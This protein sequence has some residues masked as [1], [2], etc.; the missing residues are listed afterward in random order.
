MEPQEGDS[1]EEAGGTF[2][3]VTWVYTYGKNRQAIH[4]KLVHFSVDMLYLHFTK[5]HFKKQCTPA[6]ALTK[7]DAQ[8]Y[9]PVLF[10]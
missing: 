9:F 2:I 10:L 1:G 8:T 5:L 6:L 7:H 3:V 4:S